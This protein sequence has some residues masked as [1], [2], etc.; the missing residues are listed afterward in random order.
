MTTTTT[1]TPLYIYR[2]FK[3]RLQNFLAYTVAANKISD[4][5]LSPST[6]VKNLSS[7]EC[8]ELVKSGVCE[9]F[10]RRFAVDYVPTAASY[11]APVQLVEGELLELMKVSV[12]MATYDGDGG[13]EISSLSYAQS[14]LLKTKPRNGDVKIEVQYFGSRLDDLIQHVRAHL[15]RSIPI[16]RGRNVIVLIHFPTCID[17]DAAAASISED[18]TGGLKNFET[19]STAH[20]SWITRE[21]WPFGASKL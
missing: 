15:S 12:V 17:R 13:R 11:R 16:A 4:F 19:P 9:R 1:T 6:T 14:L 7:S 18:V 21:N 20:L 3:C 8:F 5:K 2:I 10:L